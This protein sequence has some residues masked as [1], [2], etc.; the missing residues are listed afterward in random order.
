MSEDGCQFGFIIKLHQQSPVDRNLSARQ[1]PG[2][3]NRI[4]Q[5]HELIGQHIIPFGL[6]GQALADF[7]NIACQLKINRIL[8]ALTLLGRPVL[9]I[10]NGYFILTR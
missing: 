7:I 3:G 10:A 2:I 1:S 8:S 5:Y 9:L 6:I 4:I